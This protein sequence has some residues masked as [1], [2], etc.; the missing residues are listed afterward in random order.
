MS[1][2]DPICQHTPTKALECYVVAPQALCGRAVTLGSKHILGQLH[3]GRHVEAIEQRLL[4][5]LHYIVLPTLVQY[6]V[7]EVG[8]IE[9]LQHTP[10]NKNHT[11][12][13]GGW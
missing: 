5:Y 9:Y 13:L 2:A 4:L 7:L 3:G 1:G 10:A 6:S 8:W 12:Q 11:T